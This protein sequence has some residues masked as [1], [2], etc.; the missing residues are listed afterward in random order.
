MHSLA[1]VVS[2]FVLGA[3]GDEIPVAE[4]DL[5]ETT[6]SYV[7][8]LPADYDAKR[9]WPLIVDFHG[10]IA[11]TQK[12]ANLTRERLWSKFVAEA[13]YLVV[14]LN[15]R[16]R[17]WGA[18]A[19]EKD[20][21]AYALHVLE[22]VRGKYSID[23]GRI[24]VAGFSSGSDFLCR[25]GLQLKGAFAGS[26]VVC[27][28]PPTVVGLRDGAL[29]K[30]KEQPFF[31]LTG[32]E[33]YIRK[34][35]SWQAFMALDKAGARAMYREVRGVAHA[36]PPV[37]EY[38]RAMH[39]LESLARADDAVDTDAELE[40]A[41]QAV[42]REDFLLASTHLWRLR[43]DEAM[44]LL[45]EIKRRGR[46]LVADAAAI[47]VK[48]EPGKA[49]EAWWRIRTQFYRFDE[50]TNRAAAELEQLSKAISARDLYRHRRDWFQLRAKPAQPPENV[51]V[52]P[53]DGAPPPTESSV[54]TDDPSSD[55]FVDHYLNYDEL[56]AYMKSL[57]QRYP[58]R[59]R[60]VSMGKSIEGREIWALEVTD[61]TAGPPESKPAVY[62]QGA[63]HGNEISSMTTVLYLAWQLAAN[64][65]GSRTTDK[66]ARTTTLYAAPAVNPD[67]LHHFATE[68]HSHWRP[69]YNYRPFDDDRDGKLDEDPYED[70][71]GDGEIG[72]M[73]ARDEQGAFVLRE[74]RLVRGEGEPRYRLVG[75][76]GTDNDGDGK[77][78]EDRP[79]GVDLN[80]NFPVGFA[81][82]TSFGG[83]SGA[84]AASEPETQAIVEFVSARPNIAMFL[85]YH[86]DANCVF[87]WCDDARAADAAL[88]GTTAERAKSLL[89]YE[90]RP[91]DHSGA[92]LS[93]AWAYGG[94]GVFSLLVELEPSRGEPE[95][96]FTTAWQG[97]AFLPARPLKHPQLG[98]V[99]I[100]NDFKKLAKRNP[101]PADIVWQADRN[102]VFV[103]ELLGRVPRLALRQPVISRTA[104]GFRI[105]GEVINS[106][107][108]PTDSQ[109]AGGLGR[110]Y[111]VTLDVEGA[112]LTGDVS[113]GSLAAGESKP[114]TVDVAGAKEEITL[115][116]RHPRAGTVRL[117]V[118]R[119]RSPTVPIRREYTIEAGYATP[120]KALL[121]DNEF[122]D[123]GV[124][125][126]ERGPAFALKHNK[127]ELRVAVLLG[128]W[129]DQRHTVSPQEFESAFFSK[130]AY[131][132]VSA[133]GQQVYG[134]LHDFY[135]EMS[136]GKLR[137]SGKV[138]D[139][140]ELPGRW[141]EY[142]DASF[143]SSIF[144]D[145]V[146]AAVHARDGAK[147]LNEFDMLAFVWAGNTVQRT[148]ALWPM[149][150]TLKDRPDVVA[151][152]MGEY[153]L[154]EMAAIGVAC[155]E[156]GHTFGVND[157]YGLGAT[158]NPLGP[159]CLMDKGTHGGEP[160]GRHRPF[161][162]C[163]WCKS[164]IGWV[165][166]AAIDPA[167]H[168]KLAL[169]PIGF[170]PGEAFRVLLK[171]DGSEYLLLE[172]RRREGSHTDLPSPGLVVLK[173]GPNDR[174][175]APQTR[176]Q[177]LPAH[178]LPP[179]A[180][181]VI[182]Q[183]ERVAWPQPGRT[184]LEVGG[185][186][187]SD[188][189]LVDD[190]VY[191]DVALAE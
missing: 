91:L 129:K 25:G 176:V 63:L 41:K 178:G 36:F 79:G 72:L 143:G 33:D 4:F 127:S 12:G 71:D 88:L 138:F 113:L 101:H 92:G 137:V 17:A 65:A 85:D 9:K 165:K 100:G 34:D 47:D 90:P 50:L 141:A 171:P 61:F 42:D 124:S 188:I 122:Y 136:Y 59:V 39:Y 31:F 22:Q 149:R 46:S 167:T 15:G 175:T 86:N 130:D 52:P 121:A 159:W 23:P 126:K 177:L 172:N 118:L 81:S 43:S 181:G 123:R 119:P 78:S 21:V 107:D 26:L 116:V 131:T 13:P 173:V 170:G 29:L 190:V 186:R 14:G 104:E 19:G 148:S 191:F 158:A 150:L 68:P 95:D 84:R 183:P 151:F 157:K 2:L 77:Y 125:S 64:P 160:S 140:V 37:E 18:T 153:H 10:A 168:Q 174:P 142:R 62:A 60:L 82:R 83:T 156:M 169:R 182:A 5:A 152:K 120:D 44:A 11:P 53:T 147:S 180:R 108:L 102:W 110:A 49:F 187:L 67:A 163:A 55:S 106:G 54:R 103:K 98:E 145:H 16:T 112:T 40:F 105:R 76:E 114:F 185:V 111:S 135:E 134:S 1:M 32:E 48:T 51:G 146:L 6:A 133:T 80:R 30:A 75:R 117:P 115:V 93:I 179:V 24:Y 162:L 73:Y 109:M 154:G 38:A 161:H 155:H 66:L 166:P 20:D 97:K 69:R 99:L 27:P 3:E 35:G 74:G 8:S 87:Y 184:V 189:R 132:G 164:V 58:N 139:W 45:G 89:G 57:E 144:T 128:E 96:Y 7:V 56:T 70:L 94:L 28:G